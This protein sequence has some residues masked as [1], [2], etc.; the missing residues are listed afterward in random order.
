MVIFH[1]M[2]LFMTDGYFTGWFCLR[3][4]VLFEAGTRGRAATDAPQGVRGAVH[5]GYERRRPPQLLLQVR[6]GAYCSCMCRGE[7]S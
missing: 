7:V 1:G 4:M 2:I 3:L 6:R 5:G